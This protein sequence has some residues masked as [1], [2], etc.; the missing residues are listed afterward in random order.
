MRAQSKS[1]DN[2]LN[3]YSSHGKEAIQSYS[4]S[5]VTLIKWKLKSEKKNIAGMIKLAEMVPNEM[6]T[7]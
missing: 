2:L 1:I 6:I 3:Y 4:I 5:V 7:K